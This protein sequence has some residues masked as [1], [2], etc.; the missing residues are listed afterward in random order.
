LLKQRSA[1]LGVERAEY[2][3]DRAQL[4]Q[5][6]EAERE[7]VI[8]VKEILEGER[9]RFS[10]VQ[11]DLESL[12]KSEQRKVSDLSTRL[13]QE[14]A[15]FES[16]KTRLETRIE[17]EQQRLQE[18]E[19]RLKAERIVFAQTEKE[20]QYQLA[21]EIRIRKLKKRQMNDRFSAIR[22]ELTAL[23]EGAKRDARKEQKALTLKYE[24]EINAMQSSM[25]DLE[26]ELATAKEVSL[27]AESMVKDMEKQ[28]DRAIAERDALD[29]R[30]IG[31]LSQR[32]REIATLQT[33]LDSLRITVEEKDALLDKYQSSYRQLF[34]LSLKLTGKKI[35]TPATRVAGWI[36]NRRQKSES[37]GVAMQETEE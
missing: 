25:S 16:E 20:L 2:Q 13:E 7:K 12:I 29:A 33:N 21:E 11:A 35:K 9:K 32:N 10:T 22:Q 5:E 17:Q 4:K 24:K 15:R 27:S 1:E 18:V 3:K 19:D 36:R 26:S 31:M 30:Y 28:R 8:E 23:W 14:K 37:R 34:L 6:V